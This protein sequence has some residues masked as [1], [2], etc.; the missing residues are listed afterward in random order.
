MPIEEC[1]N[2][3]NMM[4]DYTQRTGDISLVKAYSKH[5]NQWAEYL[6][7]NTLF[8]VNQLTTVD[9]DGPLPNQTNLAIKGIIGIQAMSVISKKYL[10][11]VESANSYNSTAASY[12]KTWQSYATSSN[13]THLVLEYGYQSG[14]VLAFNLAM[15]KLLG[16][17]FIPDSV[18]SMQSTYYENHLAKYGFPLDSRRTALYKLYIAGFPAANRRPLSQIDLTT[19]Q[20]QAVP[21]KIVLWLEETLHYFFVSQ[22]AMTFLNKIYQYVQGLT[23][24]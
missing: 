13:G 21:T 1:G 6:V 24:S 19:L 20:V 11:D 12:L 22:I 23:S 10:G 16:L 17:N 2:M 7:A 9:F 3:I 14:D 8:P 4:L 15:D 5:L 18:N